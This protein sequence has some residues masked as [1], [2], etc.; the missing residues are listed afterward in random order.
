MNRKQN[1]RWLLTAFLAV[2]STTLF[3]AAA[4]AQQI[5]GSFTLPYAV[6]W[7][8]AEL[9]AGHY[10]FAARTSNNPFILTVRGKQTSAMIM[11]QSR[12]TL[13]GNRSSLH[14]TRVG[15]Q[16][17]VASLQLAPYGVS[18]EYGNRRRPPVLEA[19]SRTSGGADATGASTIAQAANFEVPLAVSGQ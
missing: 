2:S 6:H 5:A 1:R 10:T 16:T 19:A 17:I 11:A 7:G 9:P 4:Q 13:A 12:N 18:F 15:N 3:T 14:I 8:P